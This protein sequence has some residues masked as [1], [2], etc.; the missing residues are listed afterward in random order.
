MEVVELIGRLLQHEKRHESYVR[1]PHSALGD[2]LTLEA[3]KITGVH[4][5]NRN[6][7]SAKLSG[8]EFNACKFNACNFSNAQLISALLREPAMS[9]KGPHS[10]MH[11]LMMEYYSFDDLGQSY[12]IAQQED[13]V[14]VKLGRHSNDFMTSFYMR[15][16]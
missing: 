5:A 9:P 13:R 2:P 11:H 12:D 15:T 16:P 4:L 8:C 6:F 3:K 10:R 7:S 14:A 1:G